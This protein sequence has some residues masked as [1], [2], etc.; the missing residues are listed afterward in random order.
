[1]LPD[2]TMKKQSVE[3]DL[4]KNLLV[5]ASLFELKSNSIIIKYLQNSLYT[6]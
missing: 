3:D 4:Q 1:M 6:S 5:L 2:Y